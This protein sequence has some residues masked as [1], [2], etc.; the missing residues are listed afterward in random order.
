MA[1][2]PIIS[3]QITGGKVETVTNF[4][5]LGSAVT[6]DGECSH[7]IKRCLDL[8]RKTMTNLDS[9]L[10]SIDNTLLTKVCIVKAVVF[11]VVMYRC[12]SWTIKKVE[13]RRNDVLNCGA[14]EDCWEFH[15][16][17]EIKSINPKGNQ[18]WIFIGKTEAEAKVPILWPPSEELTHWKRPW[19]WERLRAGE[20]GGHRGWND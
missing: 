16:C 3:W 6:M 18:P 5:F 4:I 15:G 8:G 11:P 20:E 7:E 9:V 12:E 13:H 1:F 19:C 14:G 17:K 2:S 10:K